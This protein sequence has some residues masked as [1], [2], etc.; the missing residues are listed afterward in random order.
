VVADP[1]VGYRL[2]P[3]L[4]RRNEDE[5]DEGGEAQLRIGEE[6]DIRTEVA[7]ARDRCS[8][9]MGVPLADP[10]A[11]ILDERLV[12]ETL[13]VVKVPQEEGG[14]VDGGG[15]RISRPADTCRPLGVDVAEKQPP[16]SLP[17]S[18]RNASRRMLMAA[19]GDKATRWIR[20]SYPLT[21]PR[22][23]GNRQSVVL[24]EATGSPR[25]EAGRKAVPSPAE[26]AVR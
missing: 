2:S 18:D 23:W 24:R 3:V 12:G 14:P 1:C 21:G 16:V 10:E 4:G 22:K 9:G 5:R 26:V 25:H 7:V 8:A 11:A 15:T 17:S 13:G 20:C 6:P 19:V